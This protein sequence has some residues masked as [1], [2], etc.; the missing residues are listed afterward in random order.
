MIYVTGDTHGDYKIFS[1]KK[2]KNIKEGD[3]LIICGDFGFI[4]NGDAKEKKILDK[5]AKKKYNICFV[6]GTHENF[7]LLDKYPDRIFF[8]FKDSRFSL[9]EIK[10]CRECSQRNIF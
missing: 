1:Q 5:L 4:W 10:S 6:D 8:A 2:F 9:V 7:D 3:T